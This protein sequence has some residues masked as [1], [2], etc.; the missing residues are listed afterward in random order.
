MSRPK[1]N[2]EPSVNSRRT[3]EDKPRICVNDHKEIFESD[4]A[5]LDFNIVIGDKKVCVSVWAHGWPY[6]RALHPG[7]GEP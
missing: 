6:Y 1:I 2:E 4:N 3:G 5:V 7:G